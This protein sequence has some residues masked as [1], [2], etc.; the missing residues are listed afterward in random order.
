MTLYSGY[1][2]PVFITKHSHV[3]KK[4]KKPAKRTYCRDRDDKKAMTGERPAK[5]QPNRECEPSLC[6]SLETS[7]NLQQAHPAPL[8]PPPKPK[9]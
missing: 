1:I 9:P 5:G 7:F 2:C 8:N 6:V 4:Q 3:Q